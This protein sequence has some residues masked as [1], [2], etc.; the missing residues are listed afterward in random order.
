[1]PERGLATNN[2]G[3]EWHARLSLFFGL[4]RVSKADAFSAPI[5]LDEINPSQFE[6]SADGRFIREG[7]P[8]AS[9]RTHPPIASHWPL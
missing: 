8:D 1:M 2:R 3:A 7:N 4:V 9:A 6:S 5:V